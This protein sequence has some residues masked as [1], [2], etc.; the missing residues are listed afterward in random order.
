MKTG[1]FRNGVWMARADIAD[2]EEN[3]TG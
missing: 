2:E 3:A 1:R